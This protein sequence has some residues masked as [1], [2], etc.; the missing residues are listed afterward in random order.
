[1]DRLLIVLDQ[2]RFDFT[3]S[4]LPSAK[5]L[6]KEGV[7]FNRAYTASPMCSPARAALHAGREFAHMWVRNNSE[8][9]YEH[10][11][12]PH[13][14]SFMNV[15]RGAGYA[16][17]LA[18][19]DHLS[20]P[21]VSAVGM[22]A[23]GVD[24]FARAID[25]YA[26]CGGWPGVWDDFGRYLLERDMLGQHCLAYGVYGT[27]SA[28]ID[29]HVC[30]STGS[31]CGFR[32]NKAVPVETE[33]SVDKWVGSSARQMLMDHRKR[34]GQTKPWFLEVAF[35]GPHPPLIA[36][37][38]YHDWELPS[39]FDEGAFDWELVFQQGVPK[40]IPHRFKSTVN[41]RESR[42]GYAELLSRIDV[43]I[44]QILELV[45]PERSNTVI[46][47]T[48]DHGEHL[49]DHG[50][51]GKTSP[52]EVSLRIPMLISGPAMRANVV[53]DGLVSLIDVGRTFIELAGAQVPAS[54][55]S[56][57]LLPALLGSG[58]L[59]RDFVAT[60]LDFWEEYLDENTSLGRK[61]FQTAA[62]MFEGSFLKL[63]CCPAGC[64]KHGSLLPH[65]GFVPQVALMN[66]TD[67]VGAAKFEHNVLDLS[68]GF[69]V[70]EARQLMR[71]LGHGFQAACRPLL[72]R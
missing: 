16:T 71:H 40:H 53:E 55:Q 56:H 32:C 60:G 25:K 54:M 65:V 70:P 37:T 61:Q 35:S 11:P 48:S 17:M 64:R 19:K 57:S 31:E 3:G 14:P 26:V 58:P 29:T 69:G 20:R 6:A 12:T 49:G 47:L 38:T 9:W 42:A 23:A 15:L 46:V 1:M 72:N 28:C 52:M 50:F 24:V 13:M 10:M 59:A 68:S 63:I 41:V 51:F 39:A 22:D 4:Y 62:G 21:P 5:R 36:N 43:E 8:Y 44:Q 33:H 18:G 66:V 27:G 34:H 2:W 30:D 45:E 7:R 67:G